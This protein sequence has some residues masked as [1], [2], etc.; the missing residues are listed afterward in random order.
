[1]IVQ[2]YED[3]L[4]DIEGAWIHDEYIGFKQDYLI[5]HSL[6]RRYKPKSI[7]EIGT[8][9]GS[10]INVMATALPEAKIYSLDLPFDIMQENT[11]QYPVGSEGED[12]VG[13]AA[14][15]PYT[16]LRGDSLNFDYSQYQ[17]DAAFID[18]EHDFEHPFTE[19]LE[20]LDQVY[21]PFLVIYHDFNMPKV[22]RGVLAAFRYST[23]SH[24]YDLYRVEGTRI[25]YLLKY[26][27]AL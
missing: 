13:S 2:K 11:K 7:L 22:E 14:K 27:K 21:N 17:F 10:G 26:S 6:L 19:T 18:G 5:L 24:L 1:M 9:I 20:L 15:F 25:A 23:R 8:N 12:R 4:F 16:Q 3:V